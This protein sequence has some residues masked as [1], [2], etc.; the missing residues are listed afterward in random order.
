MKPS[1]RKFLEHLHEDLRGQEEDALEAL[2]QLSNALSNYAKLSVQ[3][4]KLLNRR[5]KLAVPELEPIQ[6]DDVPF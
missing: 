5:K 3:L 1:E 6:D 4:E 2:Q